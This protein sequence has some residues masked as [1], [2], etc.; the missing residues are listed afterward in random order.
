[1]LRKIFQFNYGYSLSRMSRY[2]SY[3]NVDPNVVDELKQKIED[4]K[5]FE[6]G[7]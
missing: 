4:E 1:M 5:E 7:F 6:V 2:I 3:K